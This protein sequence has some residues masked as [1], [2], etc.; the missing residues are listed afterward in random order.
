VASIRIWL[1]TGGVFLPSHQTVAAALGKVLNPV[2]GGM[3]DM[4]V[5][6]RVAKGA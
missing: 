4:L 3:A 1:D 5:R 6:G 2:L